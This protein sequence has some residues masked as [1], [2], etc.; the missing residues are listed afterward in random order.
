MHS[1]NKSRL[2]HQQAISM[3]VEFSDDSFLYRFVLKG[4]TITDEK[5]SRVYGRSRLHFSSVFDLNVYRPNLTKKGKV[6]WKL[7]DTLMTNV[8]EHSVGQSYYDRVTYMCAVETDIDTPEINEIIRLKRARGRTPS[9][10]ETV[11]KAHFVRINNVS[12]YGQHNMSNITLTDFPTHWKPV[13]AYAKSLLPMCTEISNDCVGL[14]NKQ[15][16]DK[17]L[18][19]HEHIRVMLA[20]KEKGWFT[21]K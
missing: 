18:S 11:F 21:E 1:I 12:A 3:S 7:V 9:R 10:R 16:S 17:E 15:F 8:V 14:H 19:Q 20:L 6:L 5:F 4:S 13:S 2:D